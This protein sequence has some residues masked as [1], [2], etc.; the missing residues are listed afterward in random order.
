VIK[1]RTKHEYKLVRRQKQK[2]DFL[3][4]VQYEVDF[5]NL[6]H[7]RRKREQYYF[8]NEEIEY[9]IVSRIHR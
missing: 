8:K 2:K 7:E 1:K 5:L 6:I 3:A 9:V 4:Y